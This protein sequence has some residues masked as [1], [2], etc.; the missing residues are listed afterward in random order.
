MRVRWTVR[1]ALIDVEFSGVASGYVCLGLASASQRFSNFG[2]GGAKSDVWCAHGDTLSDDVM[3]GTLSISL[4]NNSVSG[5]T[6]KRV[7][8]DG[9]RIAAAFTR[10]LAAPSADDLQFL[11]DGTEQLLLWAISSE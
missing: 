2:H 1:G 8:A 6:N 7:S 5:L 11:T 10:T 9:T 4:L 3:S